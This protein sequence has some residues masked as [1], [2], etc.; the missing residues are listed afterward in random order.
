MPDSIN[1][2]AVLGVD[3]TAT[4]DEITAAFR[5]RATALHPDRIAGGSDDDRRAAEEAMAEL[6]LAYQLLTNDGVREQYR[7]TQDKRRR[8]AAD[9]GERLPRHPS[10][11][12]VEAAGRPTATSAP[13]EPV[14]YRSAAG[15]EFAVD[16]RQGG[17]PWVAGRRRRWWRR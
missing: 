8:A 15:R 6:T 14:E 2:F 16:D 13:T 17:A 1:P 10:W 4:A 5:L 11:D 7:R 3:E 12:Q 9:R